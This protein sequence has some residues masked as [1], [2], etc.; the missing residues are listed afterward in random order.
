MHLNPENPILITGG[1]GF[2]G[3]NLVQRL[4]QQNYTITVIDNHVTSYPYKIGN[5]NFRR[6]TADISEIEID[7]IPEV[8]GIIHLASVAA[9]QLYKKDPSLVLKPNTIGTAKLIEIAKRD[10]VRILFAST[11]EVY[12]NVRW[13]K[14]DEKGIEEEN[15]A[16]VKLL[17]KRSCYSAAKRFGEEL[18]LNFKKNGGDATNFRLFNVYGPDMDTKNIGYGR[19]I[20]NFI[21]KMSCGEPIE[22][23]GDG[24]QVRSF[25]WIDEAV[26]AILSLYFYEGDLPD[27]VNIGNDEP[28]TI[29]NL[30]EKISKVLDLN[31]RVKY[32][33]MEED[34]PLWRRPCVEK[35]KSL[36]GWEPKIGLDEGLR[37][38]AN[39]KL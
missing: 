18:I 8:S 34:D 19:V 21:H 2:I 11:S 39:S 7:S 31:Y 27:A 14:T 3:R 28:I 26:E 4:I 12:G 16:I 23:F 33:E 25:L 37:I 30:A 5:P 15:N 10:G 38:I 24:T 1:D 6:I 35:I 20:P 32:L 29:K 17:S 9:P 22:I 36:T 13:D